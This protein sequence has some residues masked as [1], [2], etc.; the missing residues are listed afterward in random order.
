MQGQSRNF[1]PFVSHR[2]GEIHDE[3]S[4]DQWR[5]V[6]TKLNPADQGTRG[7]FVQVL[8]TD[9]CWWHG[10]SFLQCG[11]DE[12]PERKF[13]KAPETY[14][15][16]KAEKRGQFERDEP[17]STA[18]SYYVETVKFKSEPDPT[19]YSKWYRIQSKG[20]LEIG[21]SLVRV[22]GWINRLLA[23]VR[24]HQN[25]RVRGELTPRELRQAEEQIIKTA[26]QASSQQEYFTKD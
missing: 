1:K 9:D 16:V 19:D 8:A 18:Q 15:E 24:K 14:K 6:L 25:D 7:A 23:N 17:S 11:E 5:Y 3:S 21:I 13:G 12:W 22:T 4:P 20:K 26:Q 10:P 2:V